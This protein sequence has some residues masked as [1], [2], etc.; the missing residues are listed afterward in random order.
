MGRFTEGAARSDE[1]RE[2]VAVSKVR[3]DERVLW[4]ELEDILGGP[5]P[6]S[7][8]AFLN[9]QHPG[10]PAGTPVGRLRAMA[11]TLANLASHGL[12]PAAEQ[13]RGVL[14]GNLRRDRRWQLWTELDRRRRELLGETHRSGRT[15]LYIALS[16]DT[17]TVDYSFDRRLA[18]ETIVRVL[19]RELPGLRADGWLFPAK[20]M[21]DRQ[22]ALVRFVCLQSEHG[23]SWR[24]RAKGWRK[25]CPD[26]HPAW[27]K[28]YRGKR[29]ARRLAREFHRAEARLAGSKG[30]LAVFY[31][32]GKLDRERESR[33]SGLVSGVA[34]G[35]GEGDRPLSTVGRGEA[36]RQRFAAGVRIEELVA[37]AQAGDKAAADEAEALCRLWRPAAV[38]DL[39]AR[40]EHVRS[41]SSTH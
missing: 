3:R 23:Q 35:P 17:G 5:L 2:A 22:L 16:L 9:D 13:R 12:W 25:A 34:P 24:R 21:P 1:R 10:S 29:G 15:P 26:G 6:K 39:L 33:L 19:R 18:D 11:S 32:A 36:L 31:K 41:G 28:P 14:P 7:V 27:W 38:D 4:R 8:R 40:L 30:A 37:R 20:P